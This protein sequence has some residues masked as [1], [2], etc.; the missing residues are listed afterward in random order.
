MKAILTYCL[1]LSSVVAHLASHT[2]PPTLLLL[3]PSTPLLAFE[4]LHLGKKH[5]YKTMGLIYK[6]LLLKATF[7]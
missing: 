1:L 5:R 3:S 2:T 4:S 7:A 6:H